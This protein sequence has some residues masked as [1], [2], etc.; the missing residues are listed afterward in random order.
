[1]S[2]KISDEEYIALLEKR[3]EEN[4][5][6]IR[7]LSGIL[8]NAMD[9]IEE[10][11]NIRSRKPTRQSVYDT[12]KNDSDVDSITY[13]LILDSSDVAELLGVSRSTALKLIKNIGGIQLGNRWKISEAKLDEFI[14]KGEH[15]EL[16]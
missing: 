1:M 4:R 14:T 15:I 7:T 5:R 12:L 2:K 9:K 13:P 6:A 3:D 16:S 11:E 8:S 10:L